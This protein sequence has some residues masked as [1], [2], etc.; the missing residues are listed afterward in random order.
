MGDRMYTRNVLSASRRVASQATVKRS[1]AAQLPRVSIQ[2]K[3]QLRPYHQTTSVRMP[4]DSSS[5]NTKDPYVEATQQETSPAQKIKEVQEIISAAKTVMLTTKTASG[6][7]HSRAMAPASKEAPFVFEFLANAESGKFDELQQSE[8]VN[9]AVYDT[10]S[11]NW[12]SVAGDAS[13]STDQSRIEEI[14]NPAISAWFGDLGDGKHTGKPGDPRIQL[15]NVAVS[16]VT[17]QT[18][19]PGVL[20]NISQSELQQA[21]N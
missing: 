14:F 1:V 4:V 21:R 9:I 19:N 16:A 5:A 11:T 20:R 13:T 6:D 18:A 8:K 12:I 15:I 3:Q 17:G 7:M 10:N 2:A